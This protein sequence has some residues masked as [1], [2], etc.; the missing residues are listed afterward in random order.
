MA[1]IEERLQRIDSQLDR[2]DQLEK[3]ISRVNAAPS[4][5]RTLGK[6]F[7]AGIK[8]FVGWM[9]AELPKFLTAAVLLGFGW[10]IKDSVDL[11]IKQRQLDLSYA[12]EMQDLL[13]KMGDPNSDMVQLESSAVMLSSFGEPALPSLL[14]ELRNS[15]L[16]ANAAFVGI[17]SLALTHPDAVCETLPRILSNRTQQ[18]DWLV[19]MKIVS[20][21]GG[22]GCTKAKSL[23]RKYRTIVSDA[24]SGNDSAFRELVRELPVAPEEDY[25]KLLAAIDRSLGMLRK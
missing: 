22:N 16:R 21:L 2:F 19:H 20:L 23:L 8:A 10:G 18:Y 6:R 25:P 14:S 3:A 11:S 17:E 9:G 15:G 13:K 7:L 1:S 5:N 24:S 4:A 12:K